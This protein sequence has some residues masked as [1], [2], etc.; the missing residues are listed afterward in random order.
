MSWAVANILAGYVAYAQS[1]D[2]L[3]RPVGKKIDAEDSTIGPE[4]T[5]S[6]LTWEEVECYAD[7]AVANI[8]EN[9]KEPH[10]LT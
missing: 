10:G 4:V 1:L 5:K 7:G 2:P 8:V 6:I 3:V 9:V